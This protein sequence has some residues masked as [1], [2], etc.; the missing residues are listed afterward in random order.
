MSASTVKVRIL[1]PSRTSPELRKDTNSGSAE[2]ELK[3]TEIYRTECVQFASF[4]GDLR[5][6]V[7]VVVVVVATGKE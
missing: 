5:L 1:V 3:L 6:F 2:R 4:G 7:V